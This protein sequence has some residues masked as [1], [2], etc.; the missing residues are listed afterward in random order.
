[1]CD[2]AYYPCFRRKGK[3]LARRK[4][5]E[6]AKLTPSSTRM[7]QTIGCAG[8]VSRLV[9]GNASGLSKIVRGTSHGKSRF[10]LYISTELSTVDAGEFG[11]QLFG[12][13]E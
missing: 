3:V 6:S 8:T 10:S 5:A 7:K 12:L 4:R 2:G 13:T 11:A 9:T 1:M